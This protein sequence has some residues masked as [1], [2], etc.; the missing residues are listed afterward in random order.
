MPS[1][2]SSKKK[3]K[4]PGQKKTGK[5]GKDSETRRLLDT[6]SDESRR[7]SS[8]T[9]HSDD[10]SK[11]GPSKAKVHTSRQRTGSDTADF[12]KDPSARKLKDTTKTMLTELEKLLNLLRKN[13]TAEG[14]EDALKLFKP[15][16][17]T[18]KYH[19]VSE[20]F[21]A[22]DVKSFNTYNTT[23]RKWIAKNRPKAGTTE[24]KAYQSYKTAFEDFK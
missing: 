23:L 13:V 5:T 16:L 11:A 1:L 20:N 15:W 22:E 6:S 17:E 4:S 18:I 14:D 7:N 24:D 2:G 12:V 10:K 9:S 8:V 3:G 21:G 19:L